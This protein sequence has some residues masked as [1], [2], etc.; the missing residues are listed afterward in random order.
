MEKLNESEIN[1]TGN[2]NKYLSAGIYIYAMLAIILTPFLAR[3][4]SPTFDYVAYGAM[5][6]FFRELLTGVLWVF[7]IAV[8]FVVSW[9]VFHVNIIKN[10]AASNEEL[11]IKRVIFISIII[12]V[13]ILV[14]SAQIGFQVKPFYDL[15]EKFT[16]YELM[17]N[18]GKFIR[19]FAKC[20]WITI[21]LR[22]AQEFCEQVLNKEKSKLIFG[23]IILMLTLGV[24][25]II[26]GMNNL[27]VTYLFLNL[28]FG[29][30]YLLTERNM[31][32]AYL[33]I[34]FVFF[35]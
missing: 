5:R 15:G 18:L 26:M 32:K 10:K 35:F 27:P 23:G 24:Y 9:R 11:P 4:I 2:K 30:I 25:D 33:L 29:W 17:N 14:I 12:M 22:F 28:V 8:L 21:M 31:S 1:K 6:G 34:L 19:N 13:C 20:M 3:L 7:E 16:G